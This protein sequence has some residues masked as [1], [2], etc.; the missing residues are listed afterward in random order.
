MADRW[1]PFGLLWQ[2]S[3]GS[4]RFATARM[5]KPLTHLAEIHDMRI[6][7][8]FSN[9]PPTG[10]M[11]VGPIGHRLM[12]LPDGWFGQ[13]LACVLLAC[14][15][16]LPPDGKTLQSLKV[17]LVQTVRLTV[18]TIVP[19]LGAREC[20]VLRNILHSPT[21]AEYLVR[22]LRS[23]SPQPPPQQDILNAAV[24]DL[25]LQFPV[26]RP[27]QL[28]AS[29]E[30]VRFPAVEYAMALARTPVPGPGPWRML[31]SRPGSIIETADQLALVKAHS[32]ATIL[33]GK[34]QPQGRRKR[35]I[36]THLVHGQSPMFG[37]RFFTVGDIEELL[38]HGRLHL[39]GILS[40]PPPRSATPSA[41]E[42][43]LAGLVETCGGQNR[44][45]RCMAANLVAHTLLVALLDRSRT[46]PLMT[47]FG[48]VWLIDRDR[49]TLLPAFNAITAAAGTV[50][51]MG[52]GTLAFLPP[53]DE[54]SRRLLMTQLA[55][56]GLRTL[57]E[58]STLCSCRLPG[59][60]PCHHNG[61]G[62][63]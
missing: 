56:S 40:G 30:I 46:D 20:M 42:R 44:A 54:R 37:R 8:W 63:A 51:V 41:L 38:H 28:Q 59:P 29:Q 39:E 24:H 62:N 31:Q 45:K 19:F 27:F 11:P 10:A 48:N 50:V 15:Q 7:Y 9:F 35:P 5:S 34:F 17:L 18:K 16:P 6:R 2:E 43:I 61:P 58:R 32:S 33:C 21:L 12:I 52:T 3:N 22:I 14:G 60:M 47:G 13:S 49:H 4:I 53:D 57:G 25:S 26:A 23:L 36:V 55:R 1:T